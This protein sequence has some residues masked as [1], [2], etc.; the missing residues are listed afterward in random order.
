MNNKK[1]NNQESYDTFEIAREA[2]A[3]YEEENEL[4]RNSYSRATEILNLYA[5]H[6]PVGFLRHMRDE[7][8]KERENSPDRPLNLLFLEELEMKAKLHKKYHDKDLDKIDEIQDERKNIFN[9]FLKTRE[10]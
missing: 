4:L 1:K 3:S 6:M 5:K 8:N 10:K 9:K 2:F 7:M